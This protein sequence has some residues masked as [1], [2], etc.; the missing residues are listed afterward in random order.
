M[1]TP[2]FHALQVASVR[3]ETPHAVLVEFALPAGLRETFRHDPGQFLTLR[4]TLGGEDLRRSYSICTGVDE[5][6]LRVAIKSV[7]GGRFST[8]ANASLQAGD[9]LEVMPPEGRF[10]IVPDPARRGHYAAFAAGSGITPVLA[11]VRSVLAREPGSRVTLV[12]GN[13]QVDSIMFCEALEDLKDRYLGRLTLHHVLSRQ[14]QE[15]GLFNGRI[16]RDKC[17]RL[18]DTLLPV[19]GIDQALVCGPGGMIEAVSAALEQAGLPADRLLVERFAP[20]GEV[21]AERAGAAPR[22]ASGP[23]AQGQGPGAQVTV[24]ADG[25]QH[26]VFVPRDG[27]SILEAA[28]QAGADLPYACKAGVCST[29]RARLVSGEVTMARNFALEAGEV[30]RG[31][32]LTCQSHPRSDA[33]TVDYD[34]R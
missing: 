33:V 10:R 20:V 29:C 6:A 3:K 26:T 34:Q 16:D 15:I 1:S 27:E 9:T 30:A 32:I 14:H 4:R 7:E 28:L 24:I 8:W 12:Y 19:A 21:A 2:R 13:R 5:T 18:F 31:Y 11:I 23:G 25:K 22:A 17:A